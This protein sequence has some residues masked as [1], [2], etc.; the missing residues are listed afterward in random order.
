MYPGLIG[1][2]AIV[3]GAA[4][5]IGAAVARRL[6]EEGVKVAILDVDT[7][8]AL[9]TASSLGVSAIGV[10]CDIRSAAEVSAAVSTVVDTFGGIDI[11]VNNAGIIGSV[12]PFADYPEDEFMRVIDVNLLGTYRMT[13]AALPHLLAASPGSRVVNMASIAGNEGHARMPAYSASKAGIV[14]L[15]KS[16][17]QELGATGLLINCVAPGGVGGTNIAASDPKEA[18]KDLR[19]I[20]PIGRLA[21]ADEVA[22][23]VVWLCSDQMTFSTGAVFDIS[24]GRATY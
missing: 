13:H 4:V 9:T 19:S 14:A 10:R 11:L 1:K 22:A 21:R 5:G 15:T 20:H 12:L 8:A 17:G 24:G 7:S 16:L 2:R 23:L 6:V 18:A 3:T